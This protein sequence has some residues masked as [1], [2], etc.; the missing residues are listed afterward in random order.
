[1][2]IGDGLAYSDKVASGVLGTGCV[3][4]S[5]GAWLDAA[6]AEATGTRESLDRAESAV[7]EALDR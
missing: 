7:G 4:R 2:R 1:M 6:H 3:L 5:R